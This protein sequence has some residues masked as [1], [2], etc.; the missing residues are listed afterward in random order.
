MPAVA[1]SKDL[2]AFSVDTV[3]QKA[4]LVGGSIEWENM[5]FDGTVIT[6]A[7]VQPTKYARKCKVTGEF[8][9]TIS[10][11]VRATLK[12]VSAFTLGGNS[13]AGYLKSCTMNRTNA[14]V[15]TMGDGTE[16]SYP[17]FTR[18]D[19]SI[20]VELMIAA[21]DFPDFMA[22]MDVDGQAA[23]ELDV[24]VTSNSVA[25]TISGVCTLVS[26]P[27]ESGGMM[28]ANLTIQ[29]DANFSAPSGT[30]TMLEKG[31]NAPQT[32]MALSV[33]T[34]ATTGLTVAG[35]F[36]PTSISYSIAEG[37]PTKTSITW[38]SQGA[39]TLT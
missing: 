3:D 5:T 36:L 23:A 28:K 31:F 39:I 32:V 34:K 14:V 12:D 26:L 33:V 27:I 11:V 24:S 10:G 30:T 16:S 29:G 21:A 7:H 6:A 19:T 2:S 13:F 22:A 17:V 9:E 37:Q 20:S 38:E 35:N 8:I 1:L 15:E 4:A 25:Y 18:A